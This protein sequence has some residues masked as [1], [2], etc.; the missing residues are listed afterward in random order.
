MSQRD[1]ESVDLP[2]VGEIRSRPGTATHELAGAVKVWYDKCQTARHDGMIAGMA[3]LALSELIVAS[4]YIL[5][6]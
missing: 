2:G 1:Y 5:L 4:I 6:R 3:L